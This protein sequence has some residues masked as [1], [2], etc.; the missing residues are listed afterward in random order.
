MARG[1]VGRALESLNAAMAEQRAG[2]S[3]AWRGALGELK[4][5]PPGWV[6]ACNA[7]SPASGGA[8]RQ[9]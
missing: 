7:I 2:G 3:A 4:E 6:R 5:A 8:G 9:A 1:P